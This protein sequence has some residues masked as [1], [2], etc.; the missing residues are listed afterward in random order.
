MRGIGRTNLAMM[1]A[2]AR[3]NLESTCGG[4]G[5]GVQID[6]CLHREETLETGA[7]GVAPSFVNV[8]S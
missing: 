3:K 5:S 2:K 7:E 8:R 4:L 6:S 1:K